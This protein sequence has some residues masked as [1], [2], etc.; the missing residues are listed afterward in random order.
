MLCCKSWSRFL[1][2]IISTTLASLLSLLLL[3]LSLASTT[4]VETLRSSA[5]P[6]ASSFP[7]ITTAVTRTAIGMSPSGMLLRPSQD[8]LS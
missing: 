8:R 2:R 7:P 4:L 1:H 6:T 5:R 3:H